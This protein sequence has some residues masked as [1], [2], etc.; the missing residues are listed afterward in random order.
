MKKVENCPN[1][2]FDCGVACGMVISTEAILKIFNKVKDDEERI[3]IVTK[4]NSRLNKNIG[5]KHL[6]H[7]N[8]RYEWETI[9]DDLLSE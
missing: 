4:F 6:G 8:E 7:M 1:S 5:E 9:L 3:R 2:A